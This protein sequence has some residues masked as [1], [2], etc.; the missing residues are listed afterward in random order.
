MLLSGIQTLTLLDFPEKVSALVFT[1]GCNF[2]CGYC[3]NPQF[4]DPEQIKLLQKDFIP[5]E[6]FFKFL[7]TRKNFLDGVVISGGEPTLHT[8]LIDFIKKIKDMGFLVKLDTNGTNPQILEK[9]FQK[10]FLDYIAMDV[11][12]APEN[13]SKI[14]NPVLKCHGV[15][16]QEKITKSRDL[17]LKS[18]IKHEFRTT[19]LQELHDKKEIKKIAEFCQNGQKYRL[20]NF[21]PQ[22][23]LD[24]KFGSFH[25]VSESQMREFKKI[26]EVFIEN[27]VVA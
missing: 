15:S 6:K 8:D 27:V 5:E 26:A 18:G 2:R 19:V 7:E 20:Q 13:F 10:N 23:T 9:L 22:K 1:P 14:C 12:S 24:P 25:G 4:V 16:L 3:H 21:R 17:I 11:K